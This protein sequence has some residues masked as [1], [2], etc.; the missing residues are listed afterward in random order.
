MMYISV[1]Y[2]FGTIDQFSSSSRVQGDAEEDDEAKRNARV[3]Q[4]RQRT[5]DRLRSLKQ[6]RTETSPLVS[7]FDLS[8][9]LTSFFV[10]A[11]LSRSGDSEVEPSASE[12]ASRPEES[13]PAAEH[14]GGQRSDRRHLGPPR[15]LR[16]SSARRLR[17]RQHVFT[18]S[19][20]PNSRLL[21][22]FPLAA[23]PLNLPICPLSGSSSASSSTSTASSTASSLRGPAAAAAAAGGGE[24]DG[25]P[26][27][28]PHPRA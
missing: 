7:T 24:G 17:L 9:C 12:S 1:C 6:V 5:L 21:T 2:L 14:S 3:S 27:E 16:S 19:R 23:S 20:P 25:K 4:E 26:S 8:L 15:T 28:A 11:A 13:R 10:I 18:H 22:S